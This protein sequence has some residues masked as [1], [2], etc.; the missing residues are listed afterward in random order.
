MLSLTTV[1]IY[2]QLVFYIKYPI[3]TLIYSDYVVIKL[4]RVSGLDKIF[5]TIFVD[6]FDVSFS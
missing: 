1:F 3:E 2:N 4:Q 6:L 5:I